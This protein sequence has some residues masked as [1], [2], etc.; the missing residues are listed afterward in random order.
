MEEKLASWIY[1]IV[2][3]SFVL[4]IGGLLLF[5]F[6]DIKDTTDVLRYLKT[7]LFFFLYFFSIWLLYYA[8]SK[9][10]IVKLKLWCGSLTIH[11]GI[12]IYVLMTIQDIEAGLLFMIPEIAILILMIVGIISIGRRLQTDK[13]N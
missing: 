3:S 11:I 10:D 13:I 8:K 1:W 5:I 12:I 9:E 4:S 7:V 2:G 6:P